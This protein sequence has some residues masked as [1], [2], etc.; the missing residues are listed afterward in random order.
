MKTIVSVKKSQIFQVRMSSQ[1]SK[2]FYFFG[3]GWENHFLSPKTHFSGSNTSIFE[4]SRFSKVRDFRLPLRLLL[5]EIRR[6]A[7]EWSSRGRQAELGEL[8]MLWNIATC[9]PIVLVTFPGAWAT[10]RGPRP[11]ARV[12]VSFF[13][14]MF[15]E[16]DQLQISSQVIGDQKQCAREVKSGNLI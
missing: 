5:L 7:G 3:Q 9:L 10:H 2:S 12:L 15:Q 6:G 13:Y 16:Q 1:N 14:Q 8:S 4:I 11:A